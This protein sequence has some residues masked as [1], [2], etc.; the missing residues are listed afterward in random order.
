CPRLT[1]SEKA[2]QR[3]QGRTMAITPTQTQIE[4]LTADS[5]AESPVVMHNLLRFK[6]RADGIDEGMSRREAYERYAEATA[7]FLTRVGGRVLLAVDAE[8]TVIGPESLEW[9]MA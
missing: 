3:S 9:D 8:Q 1:Y 7:P 4:Q 5:G 2:V 6:A